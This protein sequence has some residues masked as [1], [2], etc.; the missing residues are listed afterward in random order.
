MDLEPLGNRDTRRSNG[1]QRASVDARSG[2]VVGRRAGGPRDP[3]PLPTKGGEMAAGRVIYGDC[4]L[5][6]EEVSM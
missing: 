5:G 2:C 1:L 4:E 3:G 6:R